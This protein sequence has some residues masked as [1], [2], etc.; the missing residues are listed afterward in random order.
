MKEIFEKIRS[1]ILVGVVVIAV[2]MGCI[3]L[4]TIQIVN[5]DSY[6]NKT[7]IP[8]VYT[9]TIKSVRGEIVDSEGK[10][11]IENK[12]GYNVIIDD[13]FFPSDNKEAN[14]ILMKTIKILSENALSWNDTMPVSK[15][16][17]YEFESERDADIEK[18]KSLLKLNVYATAENCIDKLIDDYEITDE[19][20]TQSD[21]R[22]IAGIRYEML[23]RDF[24]IGNCFTL[25]EDVPIDTVTK[26]KELG[27][28][29]KG[30]DIVEE[31]VREIAQGD[32]IPHEIGTVGP[33]FADEYEEL[34]AKGYAMNDTVGKSGLEKALENELKGKDGKKTVTIENG[35][36]V[37]ADVTQEPVGG[38]SVKLTVNS[39]YQKELQKILADFMTDL[40][41]MDKGKYKDVNA[42]ALVVLDT[43]SNAVLG[44]ATAPT[45]NLKDYKT[46][47][48]EILNGEN[49][50]LLDRATDGLYRPGST[51][52]PITATAGLNE[53]IVNGQSTYRCQRNYKYI[54][55]VMH[56][57][58]YHNDIS[59]A[60]ALKV[61]CN[62]YFYELSQRLGIDKLASY[63]GRYGYGKSTGIECGDTAGYVACPETYNKLN[64]DWTVGHLLQA[65]IGQS[66]TAVTP[67]QMAC[68]ASTIANDGVRYTPH[69][70]DSIYDYSMDN[71]IEEKKAETADTIKLNY[72]YVY[73][74]VTEGMVEASTNNIPVEH[75]LSNLGYRVAIKTGTPQSPRGTDSCFIGFAPAD[76]PK[77]AF[78]GIVEGG[79]YSKYMIRDI[80]KSYEKYYGE[81][82]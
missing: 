5:G 60:G 35:A 78:A 24:S 30:I 7:T 67:L 43:E 69:L 53:G 13:A 32:V 29:L 28:Q 48:E 26:L 68:V 72:N 16:E 17:P 42:G 37:S 36:V 23:L 25:C 51:F 31:A 63:A 74:Y 66:E 76:N 14:D 20:Y 19:K 52:K 45:Y 79:E 33:I 58:G 46:K 6:L 56:C 21:I 81:L 47:Y 80:I 39:E 57:T 3:K 40:K 4:M 64:M 70:V 59:V 8:S 9:Q 41:G 18:M 11:I 50:P 65:G 77:I 71:V 73:D 2:A 12:V 55:V 49:T 1:A 22:T 15:A 62:I 34:K 10:P 61:S 75:S 27:V 44:M 38:H 54:D 82:E